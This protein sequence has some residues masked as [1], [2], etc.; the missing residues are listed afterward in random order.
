MVAPRAGAWIETLF[1]CFGQSLGQAVVAQIDLAAALLV[2]ADVL[3]PLGKLGGSLVERES[4]EPDA[5]GGGVFGGQGRRGI[6][7][8][9]G[10]RVSPE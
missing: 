7:A 8:R 1:R 3:A 6:R 10:G 2:V 9:E 4:F 5:A